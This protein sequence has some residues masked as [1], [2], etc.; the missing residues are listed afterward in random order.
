MND[1]NKA[2]EYE[3]EMIPQADKFYIKLFSNNQEVNIERYDYNDI[4]VGREMQK[5]GVDLTLYI[6]D[7]EG[8]KTSLNLSE[9]FRSV[10]YN[11]MFIELYSKHP[12]V[13]GWALT[14]QQVDFIAYHTPYDV[15]FVNYQDISKLANEIMNIYG[16]D[17]WDDSCISHV[18]NDFTGFI[19]I[20]NIV[21]KIGKNKE[22]RGVGMIISWETLK[23]WGIRFTV[24]NKKLDLQ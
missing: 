8:S 6:T 14:S 9:K 16:N 23:K 21:T 4:P 19:D 3:K 24:V 12:H 17:D 11:D 15:Y 20:R 10:D 13:K 1:F 2:L 5:H 7:N 18:K 22:W